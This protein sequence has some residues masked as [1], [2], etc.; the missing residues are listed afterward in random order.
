MSS[1]LIS[2]PRPPA[3]DV[4]PLVAALAAAAAL[5]ALAAVAAAATGIRMRHV[6]LEMPFTTVNV[7]NIVKDVDQTAATELKVTDHVHR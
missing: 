7:A 3:D 1:R 2:S 4:L 6:R 5:A